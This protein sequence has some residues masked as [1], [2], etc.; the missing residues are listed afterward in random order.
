MIPVRRND[1]TKLP[2]S[3]TKFKF[4]QFKEK[5]FWEILH[6][7]PDYFAWTQKNAKSPGASEFAEWVNQHFEYRGT[8]VYRRSG[9]EPPPLPKQHTRLRKP[10]RIHQRKNVLSATSSPVRKTQIAAMQPLLGGR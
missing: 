9:L 1:P 6:D 3:N 8:V 7:H 2:G 4:G 10:H 5:T